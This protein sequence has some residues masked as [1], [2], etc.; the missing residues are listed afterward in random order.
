M[1]TAN[2]NK[3]LSPLW[4][5]AMGLAVLLLE[6]CSIFRHNQ[7]VYDR[8][9]I[10]YG[11]TKGT[12]RSR[13]W[14]Y[15]ERGCSYLDGG[16]YKE[17][18]DDFRA[19][20]QGR[21]KDQRWPRTYGLH[22][23]PE[24]F[25]NRELGIA[26]Y[27]QQRIEE[28]LQ[29]IEL[30]LQ[31]RF[32]ARAA[33]YLT[34]GRREWLAAN[35]IDATP[36]EIV[37]IAPAAQVAVGATEV[38]LEG[39]ARDDTFVAGIDIDGQPYDIR[40]GAAEVPFAKTVLLSP[41]Q[42]SVR[43]EVSD[44]TGKT[45][46]IDVPIVSDVDGPLVSFD[47]PVVVPG[48]LR[49]VIFDDSGIASLEISGKEATLSP[50][51]DGTVAFTIDLA[52][53]EISPP[54]RY[55]CADR[56]GNITRGTLPLD[57]LVLN[58]R[59]PEIL[60]S[61]GSGPFIPLG[62]GLY[63]LAIHGE[64][65]AIAAAH[66][67]D[68]GVS[69]EMSNVQEGQQYFMDEI[70]VALN[71]R[72]E[73]PIQDLEL[74]DQ[75]IS[76]IPGRTALRMSRKIRLEEGANQLMARAVDTRGL[77]GADRKTVQREATAIEMNRGK[78]AVAFLGNLRAATQAEA[79]E[80]A[81]YILNA[82][83]ATQ[84]VQKRF[85]VVDRTLLKEILAE[86]DLSEALASRR[87]KLALG[88]LIPAEMMIAARIRR[89]QE[90]I[91]IVLEGSST[92]TAVRI[93]PQV[94]V[95]GSYAELDRLIEELGLRLA[96]ELPRVQ[97]RVLQWNR[98]EITMD[99]NAGQGIRDNLKCLIFRTEEV[100]H[101]ETGESLGA[102]PVILCEGLLNNVTA[103]FSTAEALPAE[104]GQDLETLTIETGHYVVIK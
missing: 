68:D 58:P 8:D 64:N 53:D 20:L 18:E 24:Y 59:I 47:T 103:R 14:N 43:V 12:F 57:M 71:V 80:D 93:L 7:P 48:I 15:Y 34:E 38:V 21:A 13:W 73:N 30:S 88:K 66:P 25:P 67:G 102:R 83:A 104:E 22:F 100:V 77:A 52:M 16:F 75:A 54:L 41:G 39:I 50:A 79:D 92:E 17:A 101:P 35:D 62:N 63:A 19:A 51:P 76:T 90:S 82:L 86:Q 23:I 55:E 72:S 29:Q 9:G 61:S 44:L 56:L 91:E 60:F 2:L 27:H 84:A 49:G 28:S 94:D 85:T 74:N 11:V 6:G 40:L 31:Q 98:P 3:R 36:P 45:A 32:S 33:F 96:Q 89:D 65:M 10:Q 78:L 42:N 37:I 46:A 1:R 97:G 5:L 69:V 4:F 99:L 26:L 81:E 87:N 95:A 70:V